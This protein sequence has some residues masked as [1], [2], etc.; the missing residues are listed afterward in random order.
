MKRKIFL[1]VYLCSGKYTGK[2]FLVFGIACKIL[3]PN[4]KYFPEKLSKNMPTIQMSISPYL[5]TSY[6]HNTRQYI[7][8]Q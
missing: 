5:Y 4:L 7:K 1:V 3:F 8:V 2:V 6:M